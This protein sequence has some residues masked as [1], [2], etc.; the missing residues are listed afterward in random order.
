MTSEK[1]TLVIRGWDAGFFSNFNGVL[2]NLRDRLGRRGVTAATVDWHAI[3]QQGQISPGHPD[4]GN[5]WLQF[6]EPLSFDEFPDRT[7][8]ATTFASPRMTGRCAYAMYKLDRNWRRVY[9]ALYRRHVRIRPAI[10]DRVEEIY[11]A[12]MKGRYCAGVHYRHPEHDGECL[13]PIA[14]PDVFV[15]RLRGMLPPDRPWVVLLASDIEP[16]VDVFRRAFGSRLVLQPGVRRAGPLKEETFR[17]GI[18]RSD[19]GLAKEVLIDCLLLARRELLLHVTSNVAT[20]VGYLNPALRMVYC[21]TRVQAAWGYV[22]SIFFSSPEMDW[23]SRWLPLAFRAALR[24]SRNVWRWITG[25]PLIARPLAR[26]QPRRPGE[27]AS[28]RA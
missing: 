27:E 18:D 9:H 21:E 23:L 4:I 19:I 3:G 13:H 22:W 20:A 25:R 17:L 8:Q 14:S 10:L 24:R 26:E 11:R 12:N 5:L 6:F 28:P 7:I 2:N 1:C 15:A 16:A